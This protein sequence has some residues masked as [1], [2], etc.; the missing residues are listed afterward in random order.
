MGRTST[1][2]ERYLTEP[3]L[4]GGCWTTRGVLSAHWQAEGVAQIL[5]DRFMQGIDPAASARSSEDGAPA[6]PRRGEQ[7]C[8]T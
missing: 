2:L 3:V 7:T 5:I 4:V 1:A 6:R 8:S